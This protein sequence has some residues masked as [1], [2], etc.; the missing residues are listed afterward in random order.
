MEYGTYHIPNGSI[1]SFFT[2]DTLWPLNTLV[3]VNEHACYKQ[4]SVYTYR[5]DLP[6]RHHCPHL[7]C[8]QVH[9]SHQYHQE[10]PKRTIT[11]ILCASMYTIYTRSIY[12]YSSVHIP[13]FP[14]FLYF[15][16]HQQ[17]LWF[18]LCPAKKHSS[19]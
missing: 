16:F 4:S 9:L 3:L 12:D 13:C 11:H 10:D 6:F 19:M 8:H 18:H 15:L 1:L 17:D 14:S 5:E 7:P 2:F